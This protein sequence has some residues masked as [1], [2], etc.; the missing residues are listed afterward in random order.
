MNITYLKT[1]PLS[2]AMALSFPA[3]LVAPAAPAFAKDA[4]AC[5]V[6]DG[7]EI[8][9]ACPF[10]IELL[11]C[12]D[13]RDCRNNRYSN[14]VTLHALNRYPHFGGDDAYIRYGACKGANTIS[15]HEHTN[16]TYECDD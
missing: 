2:L 9:N 14:Q 10:T 3:A 6:I 1:T 16:F 13:G 12:V 8:L 7:A 4:K 15:Q 11:W 5:V